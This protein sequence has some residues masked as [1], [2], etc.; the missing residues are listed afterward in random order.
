MQTQVLLFSVYTISTWDYHMK[1]L[2]AYCNVAH[3]SH[4]SPDHNVN[5]QLLIL[6][7]NLQANGVARE[8]YE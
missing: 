7:F 5:F 6:F 1:G 8:K 3:F 2:T 4:L